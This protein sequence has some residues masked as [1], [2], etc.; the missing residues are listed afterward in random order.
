MRGKPLAQDVDLANLAKQT[1]GFTGADIENLVNEAAILAARRNKRSIDMEEFQEA[2]ERVAMGP[3]RRSRLISE[4]EK[5]ITAY[6]EG[7]HALVLLKLP[8]ADPV[9]KV[10]I[11]P[12]GMAGGYTLE[13]PKDDRRVTFKAQFEDKVAGSLG[14]RVA[15]ELVLGDVTTG[16]SLDLRQA[17][18]IARAMITWGRSSSH[19]L[20]SA[21]RPQSRQLISSGAMAKCKRAPSARVPLL[22]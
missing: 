3:E 20:R 2:I 12:R 22:R 9:H 1:P 10:T 15:E 16:A 18:E 7:G 6:H 14:G 8:H 11:I 19:A 5:R 13:L 4:E 17:T 21:A